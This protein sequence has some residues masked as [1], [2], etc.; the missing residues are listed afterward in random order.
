MT[1]IA[2]RLHARGLRVV[3]ATVLPMCNPADSDK[4]RARQAVNRWIRTTRVFDTVVDFDA[5]LRDP[6]DP[7]VMLN[8][9]KFDCYHPN[10]AGDAL[11]G[12]AIPLKAL[13]G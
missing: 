9:L 10:A 6:A 11:L 8:D 12:A 13:T 2:R 3:G 4:E 5:V 1:A 7:T